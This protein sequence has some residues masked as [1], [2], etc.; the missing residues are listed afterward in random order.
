MH[1]KTNQT[2]TNLEKTNKSIEK[3]IINK[4]NKDFQTNRPP[5]RVIQGPYQAEGYKKTNICLG[6]LTLSMK[7]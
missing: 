1:E 3:Y 2:K 5:Y 4:I 7:N 6:K